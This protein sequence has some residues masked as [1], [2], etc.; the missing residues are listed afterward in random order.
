MDSG[1]LI[2]CDVA[3]APFFVGRF[4]WLE[5]TSIRWKDPPFLIWVNQ[6]T[7][8]AIF[9]S[10]VPNY[11]RVLTLVIL[12]TLV[13]DF[14]ST[15]YLFLFCRA[16]VTRA[17]QINN[18]CFIFVSE[19]QSRDRHLFWTVAKCCKS[20]SMSELDE[21][22][23]CHLRVSENAYPREPFCYKKWSLKLLY[24]AGGLSNLVNG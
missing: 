3:T 7:K 1:G 14:S 24:L 5:E 21:P 20:G 12:V 15:T 2:H 19:N 9:N 13:V 18:Y 6:R 11:Q 16:I 4:S 23:K 22:L 8:W 17:A 10:Y